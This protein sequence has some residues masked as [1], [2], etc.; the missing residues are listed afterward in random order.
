MPGWIKKIFLNFLPKI[1]HMERPTTLNEFETAKGK[2]LNYFISNLLKCDD[3]D[4]RFV[5]TEE[6]KSEKLV[7]ERPP[8]DPVRLAVESVCYIAEHFKKV[9]TDE[10]VSY[11][12][13]S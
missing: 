12:F 7:F 13:Y 9:R 5:T 10:H 8:H 4:E 3:E 2:T 1:L 6:L 11:L